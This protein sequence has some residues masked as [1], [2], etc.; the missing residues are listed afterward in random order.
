MPGKKSILSSGWMATK[1][2]LDKIISA[3]R[4]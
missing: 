3:G 2:G 4:Y 1:G